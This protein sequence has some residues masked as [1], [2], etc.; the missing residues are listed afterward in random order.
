MAAGSGAASFFRLARPLDAWFAG[1]EL[2]E[3]PFRFICREH[4]ANF[5]RWHQRRLVGAEFVGPSANVAPAP[6]P[7]MALSPAWI[8][9][10]ASMI[11]TPTNRPESR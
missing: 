3:Q 2:G 7:R 10:G 1:L 11:T 6:T 5:G 8:S 4:A 9:D